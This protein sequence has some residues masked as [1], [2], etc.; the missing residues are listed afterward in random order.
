M[1]GLAK[2]RKVELF[3]EYGNG[4]K[5]T[6]STEAQIAM[7]TERIA[8]MSEHLQT[9]KKDHGTRR[10]LLSCVGKRKS[11]LN[12][13]MRKDLEGYRALLPKLGLRK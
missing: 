10:S 3:K 11:L 4:E 13:L 2:E 5:D 7:L 9:N 12:Y 8:H 1:A 6:G